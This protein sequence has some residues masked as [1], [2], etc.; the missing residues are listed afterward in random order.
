MSTE[1][2][3]QGVES[4]H[5]ISAR[6]SRDRAAPSE[7]LSAWSRVATVAGSALRRPALLLS[8]LVILF[9]LAAAILPGLF[10]HLSPIEGNIA[11]R[12][13]APSITHIFGTDSL[14]RDV[15]ARVIY[16]AAS[17]LAA[18]ALAVLVALVSGSLFGLIAGFLR[19]WV[20]DV[21]MRFVDVILAIPSLL[22]SLALITALGFG[23][24]NIAI[25][26]GLASAATFS[27]VMRSEVLRIS[28]AV[29]VE[30][31]RSSGVRWY[32]IL[33]RHV[34]P[35]SAGPV[36][37]LSAL[38]FGSAVLAISTLSFL[39]FGAPPPQPEWGSLI[40]DGRNYLAVAWWLT[41]LPGLIIVAVVLSANRISRA[42]EKNGSAE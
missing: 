33:R 25:A 3:G 26:V 41:T 42:F 39:G 19:G 40:S 18:T 14:G 27:R 28:T 11:V 22:L 23:T 16:G 24:V 36:L 21:I 1:I 10:T 4:D 31:A 13:Q 17:S 8:A 29:Y 20:D 34:L 7:Q 5:A 2:L 15:Y 35:N 30:A 12:L 32:T 9:V 38:E 37:S 6:T